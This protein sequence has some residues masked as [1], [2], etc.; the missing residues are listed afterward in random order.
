MISEKVNGGAISFIDINKMF[1]IC[2]LNQGN[3]NNFYKAFLKNVDI[4]NLNEG[5]LVKY[6][7]KGEISGFDIDAEKLRYEIDFR[8]ATKQ[9]NL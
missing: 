8:N 1:S 5:W 9:Y 4:F 6:F 7:G 3:Y 2:G